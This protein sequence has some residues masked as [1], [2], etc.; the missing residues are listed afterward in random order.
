MSNKTIGYIIGAA[1]II[2]FVLSYPTIRTIFGISLPEEIADI[3]L[4][5]L[6]TVLL[7]AGAYFAFKTP[8]GKQ[9]KEVPIYHGHGKKRKVVGYQ[10]E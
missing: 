9:Q 1:G 7:I 3:Y 4:T 2:L 5:L 8:R 10:R 6:G